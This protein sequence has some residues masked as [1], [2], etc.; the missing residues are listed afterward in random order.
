[1][2][3]RTG[4]RLCIV[5]DT[6]RGGLGGAVRVQAEWFARRGWSVVLVA[7]ADGDAPEG[8]TSWVPLAPVG[9]A[10][11]PLE[12]ARAV[13]SLRSWWRM[14]RATVDTLGAEQGPVVHVHGMRSLLL[15]RLAG[16]PTPFV[17]VHGTGPDPGDP[18]GY[19]RLRR[20]WLGFVPRLAERAVTVEPGYGSGW[21][22]EPHASPLLGS[23]DVLPFPDPDSVPTI[24]WL[25]LLDQRKQ[26][27]VFVKA[28]ADVA[29]SGVAIRGL[30]GGTGPRAD[31]IAALVTELG[32]PVDLLGQT[33]P[34][35]L[36]RRSWGLALFARSEGTP[37][38]VME[39]MW[40]GRSVVGSPLPGI[41][42][43]VGGT[44]S[45]TGSVEGAAAAFRGLL[46][47]HSTAERKGRDA[48][49][50]IRTLVRRGD[51]W[52]AT[53]AA[54]LAH[55]EQRAAGSGAGM[56]AASRR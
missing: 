25:G 42:H 4:R 39:A 31:E 18:G 54:Y 34:V 13:R 37:L 2:G 1:M 24:G 14:E 40:A 32:A 48:A 22:Y 56:G 10:R 33:D 5:S 35:D 45:L 50:R 38:A 6:L 46:T 23:L 43:L 28:I 12:V 47:D 9:S 51:P 27:E 21:I 55:L 49:A 8:P 29:A 52:P 41:A 7:P 53:E 15:A 11:H 17:T 20:A 26:P 44:G 36:L 16:I 3:G 30:L 19:D